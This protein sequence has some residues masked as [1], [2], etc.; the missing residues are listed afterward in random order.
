MQAV[1]TYSGP[2]VTAPPPVPVDRLVLGKPVEEAA[3][4]LPRVFNLCRVAQGIAA[5]AA[6][7][8]PLDADWQDALLAEILKEHVVKL[9]LKW[10]ALM[11]LPAIALPSDWMTGGAS[12]RAALFGETWRMPHNHSEFP[13]FLGRSCGIA[14]VLAGIAKRFAGGEAC[15]PVLPRATP[16]GMFA[17]GPQENSVAARQADHPVLRAIERDT[18]RGPLWSAAA[19]AYDLEA[20]LDGGLAPARLAP[21]RAV[22]PAARGYYGVSA[23]VEDG[24]VAAFARITPTD[25]LL[26]DGGALHHMLATL[27]TARTAADGPLLLAILDPC[28]PVSLSRLEVREAA[29]A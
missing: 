8:L 28:V 24:R 4:L 10:P 25:H 26:A 7:G 12:L 3:A 11:S 2:A 27:D 14:P 15:R 19:V 5:R 29:H 23:R 20:C 16:D 13:A 18:G 1:A 22:V 21:E 17:P 9:C 6:F